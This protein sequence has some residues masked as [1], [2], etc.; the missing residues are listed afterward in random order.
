[1]IVFHHTSRCRSAASVA[2]VGAKSR[3]SG[4]GSSYWCTVAPMT[5]YDNM[6]QHSSRSSRRRRSACYRFN[7]IK[8]GHATFFLHRL[9]S[10]NSAISRD[11]QPV[12]ENLCG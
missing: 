8:S 11:V 7:N 1:M 5:A 4:D 9:R 2:L 12:A 3:G 6:M 10:F